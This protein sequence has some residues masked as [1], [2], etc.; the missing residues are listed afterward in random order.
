MKQL[1]LGTIVYFPDLRKNEMKVVEFKITGILIRDTLVD[2]TNWTYLTPDIFQWENWDDERDYCPEE[3]EI[4][5]CFGGKLNPK[6]LVWNNSKVLY[7][8][9]ETCETIIRTRRIED[10]EYKLKE[11]D[12]YIQE[13]EKHK[14]DY[15]AKLKYN[16]TLYKDDKNFV[17][18]IHEEYGRKMGYTIVEKGKDTLILDCNDC[19]HGFTCRIEV[20]KNEDKYRFLKMIGDASYDFHHNDPQYYF[21]IG[22][23]EFHK[24]GHQMLIDYYQGYID[25]SIEN[26][27]KLEQE[28]KELKAIK[29]K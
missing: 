10:I 23:Q 17:G 18:C 5:L 25:R 1:K 12:R 3:H 29:R 4:R 21:I 28:L 2:S 6:N 14:D 13:N 22:N 11:I 20:K 24:I 8:S 7:L 26:K 15:L 16:T 27:A 19:R 9:K